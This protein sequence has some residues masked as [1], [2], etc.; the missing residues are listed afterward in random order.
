MIRD[1]FLNLMLKILTSLF[2]LIVS[3]VR[4]IPV[5]RV[6]VGQDYPVIEQ[7]VLW[8]QISWETIPNQKMIR[9]P[10][11]KIVQR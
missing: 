8:P 9:K 7:A 11:V 4:Q 5:H 2:F 1:N 3:K 6:H 10:Q